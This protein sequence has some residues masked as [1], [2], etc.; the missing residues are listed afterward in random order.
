M[1]LEDALGYWGSKS[2]T[3]DENAEVLWETDR[4]NP[5]NVAAPALPVT[6]AK[7][8]PYSPGEFLT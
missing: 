7:K 5:M 8:R 6:V 3:E 1:D 4:P 2:A